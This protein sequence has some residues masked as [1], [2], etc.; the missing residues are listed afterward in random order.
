MYI[1]PEVL[2][3]T[4]WKIYTRGESARGMH[5]QEYFEFKEP[6]ELGMQVV[7]QTTIYI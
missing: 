2:K 7:V 5:D 6:L 1:P 3:K 4:I